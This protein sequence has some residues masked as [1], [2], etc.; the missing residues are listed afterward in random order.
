[1]AGISTWASALFPLVRESKNQ[2]EDVDVGLESRED[3]T[4]IS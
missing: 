1:M 2:I 3:L 4:S